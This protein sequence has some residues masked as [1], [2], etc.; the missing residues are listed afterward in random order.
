L[1]RPHSTKYRFHCGYVGVI[2]NFEKVKILQI[3]TKD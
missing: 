2:C 3:V 1:P